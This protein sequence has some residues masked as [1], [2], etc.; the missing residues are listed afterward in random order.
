MFD[1]NFTVPH[2]VLILDGNSE[3]GAHVG[4]NICYLICLRHLIRSRVVS[5]SIY[6]LEKDLISLMLAQDVLSYHVIQVP[7][8]RRAFSA[9]RMKNRRVNNQPFNQVLFKYNI[10]HI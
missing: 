3:I 7:W 10:Y 8:Y 2:M 1:L 4:S 5:N 9:K 6:F